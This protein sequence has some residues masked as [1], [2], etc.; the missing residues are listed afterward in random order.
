M[1]QKKKIFFYSAGEIIKT[2]GYLVVIA[3]ICLKWHT[4]GSRMILSIIGFVLVLPFLKCRHK[5]MAHSKVNTSTNHKKRGNEKYTKLK[6]Y[7]KKGKPA[8]G[9]RAPKNWQQ[10]DD[11]CDDLYTEQNEKK[12]KAVEEKNEKA[13]KYKKKGRIFV[14]KKKGKYQN[15]K[16]Y[17]DLGIKVPQYL[18]G[19]TINQP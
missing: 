11:D 8:S 19:Y 1:N 18:L 9:K 16:D 13:K 4:E 3:F 5:F 14:K 17:Q 15:Q 7:G 10:K 6:F 12:K 2:F